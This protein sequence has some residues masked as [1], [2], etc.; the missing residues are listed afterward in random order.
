MWRKTFALGFV[1][2]W[3]SACVELPP[4]HVP[5]LPQ[6]E[7]VELLAEIPN[8]DTYEAYGLVVSEASGHGS[9]EATAAARNGLRNKAA[10]LRATFVSIDEASATGA[11][12]LSGKTV[13]T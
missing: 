6:G 3:S 13:V 2:T 9:G 11:W 12:D 8:T 1:L 10:A 5:L 4:D 7:S